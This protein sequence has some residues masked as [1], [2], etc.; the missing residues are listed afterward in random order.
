MKVVVF[1]Y[2][3]IGCV[4][5][6]A[7]LRNGIDVALL[8]THKD[9]PDERIYF[10]SVAAL[11]AEAGV[12]VVAPD[13]PNS[14]AF[15]EMIRAL[16]PDAI[17]SFYYRKMLSDKLLDVVGGKA[18]NLHGSLLPKYRG[19]CPLNWAL[20]H[21]ET[22]SGVTLHK[23]VRKP[24]A[25]DIV[26]QEKFAILPEDDAKSI[27]PKMAKAA[28]TLFDKQLPLLKS[29]K[30]RLTR[31][32]ESKASYFG[33]R[34]SEDGQI[35]WSKPVKE[36][37]NLVR[38]VA[39][40]FPGAFTHFGSEK[41]VIMKA[42]PI[43]GKSST[44]PGTV[45]GTAPF[46]IAA[47]GGRLRV[48][49]ARVK[50]GLVVSGT[51]AAREM[52]LA[53]GC[54]LG[55]RPVRAKSR[56]KVLILG[57]NGFIGNALTSRLLAED[58]YEVYGMDLTADK[59]GDLPKHPRFT[60]CEGDIQINRDW[61]EYH[62]RKC[63]V[64]L[65]LVAIATPASY[66]REP[67][68]VFELDFEENLRIVRHCV[69]YNKKLIFPSTSEVY[70]MCQD[71]FFDEEK[72]NLVTG[73]VNKIRWIYSSSKQLLDRVIWAYGMEKGLRFTLF[74]PF[75]WIGPRL[76][77]LD[78]ARLGSSRVLTLFALNLVEG[79]PIRLVDGGDQK[80]CFTDISDGIEGLFRIIENE[81][82]KADGRIFNLGNP[83][84]EA[85]I[86]ELA[87]IMV[88][89]FE[90][91]PLR[92]H[93]PATPK[94]L[95]VSAK[96]YYGSG[97]QDVIHRRPAIQNAGKQL[98]WSPKVGLRDAIANSLDFFLREHVDSLDKKTA[99]KK[100]TAKRK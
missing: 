18:Y 54:K 23:M 37:G 56:T 79:T 44:V 7:L 12:R 62:I 38:A 55:K 27:I 26:G 73:P 75:N 28:E 8:V 35:D 61:I 19:R 96:E 51:Q 49:S 97:Y 66:V 45:L 63:D 80:R 5:F 65:P 17:F 33:G 15:I 87:K 67:L 93:F 30:A 31:Q 22:E 82:G 47:V 13:D 83:D 98:G 2:N 39:D 99:G 9:D 100:K 72:S 34:H 1:A 68:R 46:E 81:N 29:G 41:L 57:V 70:G 24:D 71:G 58:G 59:L 11:A 90:K 3:V 21:G 92:K 14:P 48:E 60:F 43:Q 42:T 85:S 84:N 89:I 40:P 36:V 94:I 78:S 16:K 74:R 10:D 6:K 95:E 25:G 86:L 20:L 69:K 53:L 88:A 32:D 50:D 91:H 77:S 52:G 4:G 64:I 76:D